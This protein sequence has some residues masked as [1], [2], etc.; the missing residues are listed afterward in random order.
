ML[1]RFI[2]ESVTL[3]LGKHVLRAESAYFFDV[4]PFPTSST[5]D[6][7]AHFAMGTV[8]AYSFLK[9][10]TAWENSMESTALQPGLQNFPFTWGWLKV[11]FFIRYS[12]LTSNLSCSQRTFRFVR[13]S[14]CAWW[15]WWWWEDR[16]AMM[17][18]SEPAGFL[19]FS[20][21]VRTLSQ[22]IHGS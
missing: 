8:W 3:V 21:A 9:N 13:G 6:L 7:R 20:H 17:V 18:F 4:I 2:W 5:L 1:S 22:R 11:R 10:K 12:F 14:L 19:T 16:Q 15:W